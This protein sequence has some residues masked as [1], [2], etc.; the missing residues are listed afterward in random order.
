M[1]EPVKHSC[2]VDPLVFR[3]EIEVY[4]TCLASLGSLLHCRHI[5]L[6]SGRIGHLVKVHSELTATLAAV[7]HCQ[8]RPL[9]LRSPPE[10]KYNK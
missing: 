6:V 1:P 5:I 4:T 9:G 10:A 3:E 8:G 2:F 7:E